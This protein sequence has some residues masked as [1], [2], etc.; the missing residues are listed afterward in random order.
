MEEKPYPTDE[1]G[2]PNGRNYH[3]RIPL[4]DDIAFKKAQL[5]LKGMHPYKDRFVVE[6]KE[7][8]GDELMYMGIQTHDNKGHL[9]GLEEYAHSDQWKDLGV[10]S[11]ID[12]YRYYKGGTRVKGT[13]NVDPMSFQGVSSLE[14][15][16]TLDVTPKEL[17]KAYE[18]MGDTW[19]EIQ[20]QLS[21][22][23]DDAIEK[24]WEQI[25][26]K[27]RDCDHNHVA[28]GTL[29]EYCEQCGASGEQ[30]EA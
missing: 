8:S 14:F 16:T 13:F 2:H 18:N 3:Y 21:W 25:A 23:K 28:E 1:F 4:N 26:E 19:S 7:F 22:A 24:A 9:K 30:L 29:E 10:M 12:E 6:W 20:E 5:A 27:Q 15:T 17:E 11:E